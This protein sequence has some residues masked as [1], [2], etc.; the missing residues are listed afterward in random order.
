MK[1]INTNLDMY[2]IPIHFLIHST[3]NV[4]VL[5][6]R[7]CPLSDR[8]VGK[9]TPRAA[10]GGVSQSWRPEDGGAFCG[11]EGRTQII[12]SS[13]LNFNSD[14]TLHVIGAFC[15]RETST[16]HDTHELSGLP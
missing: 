11:R 12:F 15:C 8:Q 4:Y 6:I 9:G 2:I 5:F 7:L 16:K 10:R 14:K 13:S 1:K 3:L